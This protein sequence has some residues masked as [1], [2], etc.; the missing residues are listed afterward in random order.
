MALNGSVT[1]EATPNGRD[2]LIFSW[3]ATQDSAAKTST[4]DWTLQL[5]ADASGALNVTDADVYP[6]A[7]TIDGQ[8]FSGKSN[9]H[10]GANQTKTLASGS[11]T[12][13]HA[14]D[15]TKSFAFTF[16]QDFGG[17]TWTATGD[18][19]NEVTGSGTGELDPFTVEEDPEKFDLRGFLTGLAMA[20]CSRGR[21][22]IPTR[23]PVAY[24][25]NGVRLPALPEWDRE[26]YP[27]YYIYHTESATILYCMK[28]YE[29]RR[30]NVL[31]GAEGWCV[32]G[33]ENYLRAKLNNGVWE[34]FS[35][36]G[37]I[38]YP[39]S[40]MWTVAW[41]NFE[42]LNEDGSLLREASKPDPIPVYE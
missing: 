1:V 31:F 23:T 38:L 30:T 41:A 10:I 37:S 26:A 6:W 27:Y 2:L 3:D 39:T 13:H 28:S 34:P 16:M 24:L 17:L 36:G 40:Y 7:V 32:T 20:L 15:G 11:V 33:P 35:D 14:E 4:I 19:I 18:I 5:V 29:C 42:L 8:A 21:I 22:P 25:Y 12:L 9:I